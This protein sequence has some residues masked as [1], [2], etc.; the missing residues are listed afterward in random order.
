[1]SSATR[2]LLAACLLVPCV[3]RIARCDL[4]RDSGKATLEDAGTLVVELS[5]Q[6]EQDG[7][8]NERSVELALQYVPSWLPRVNLFLESTTWKRIATEQQPVH[9]G[10]GDT[11]IGLTT[12]LRAAE[13]WSPGIL[14][15]ARLKLPTG[16]E[17]WLGSG[18]ADWS[19]LLVLGTGFERL[20][21]NLELEYLRPG[22][23]AALPG[24]AGVVDAEL[25][26]RLL[27]SLAAD[28]DLLEHLKLFS[29]L[30]AATA[31][32]ADDRPELA[33]ELG[34]EVDIDLFDVGNLFLETG[35]QTDSGVKAKL[36][37]ELEF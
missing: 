37:L 33:L 24:T 21:L 6:H 15:G 27:L 1:M 3:C 35:A 31:E 8:D 2:T 32:T 17:P 13:G 26:N 28:L 23:P 10:Q 18:S 30:G 7:G 9:T 12:L 4:A 25:K 5:A 16:Q 11:E 29:E 19:G 20:D 34:M 14:L 36:G 22:Q